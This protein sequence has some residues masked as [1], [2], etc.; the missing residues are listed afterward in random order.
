ML[1]SMYVATVPNRNSP[2]AILIRESYR[3]NGK[4]KTRTLANITNWSPDRIEALRQ[5]L[6]NKTY[7]AGLNDSFDITRSLGHGHVAAVLG[8]IYNLGL[9]KIIDKTSSRFRDLVLAMIVSQVLRPSSKLACARGLRADTR[10]SSLSE[11]LLLG[12]VS[13]NDLYDAMDW[14]YERQSGIEEALAKRH[15]QNGMLVLYDMSSAAFE[16]KT[17]P[18]GA[19]GHPK[20]GV[21][22]RLQIVYGLLTTKDGVPIAIEV[23]PGNTGE[24]TTIAKQVTKL[25]RRFG[26]AKVV[27]VGDRGLLTSA[28][29]R[30][31]VLSEQ[32]D[33]ITALRAPQIR[34]LVQEKALQL[35]LFDEMDICEITDPSYPG[36]RLIACRNPF[37]AKERSKKRLSLLEAT[38]RELDQIVQAVNRERSPIR[39]KANIALRVGKII[40]HYKM[41]KHFQI[42]IE[43]DRLS[44]HLNEEKIAA[45]AAL[46]GIYVL[47]STCD[48][49]TLTSQE[50]V[51]S[52]KSLSNVER[53]FRGFNTDLDIRPIYHRAER[54]VRVHVFLR[55]LSYYVSFHMNQALAPMLF[56][57]DDPDDAEAKRISPV[58]PAQRSS[59]AL[60]KAST[61]RS[62]DNIPVHSFA[63]LMDDL[64]SVVANHITPANS[65]LSSFV[66][67]TKPTPIQTRAFE[68]L[69]VSPTLGYM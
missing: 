57:D 68:L 30:Q 5:V 16:G 67:V 69:G 12:D 28:R 7:K 59:K 8:S 45:E 38:K 62:I 17:C 52:Y 14:L 58:A 51:S 31:D 29:L 36:E 66:M 53:V 46:D 47:R 37:L 60:Y 56:K 33:F 65:D 50:V 32:L 39:G 6:R 27:L 40:N 24:P 61:K 35:S 10:S 13:S 4:V 34:A 15:L 22:G 42:E 11:V 44:Y 48:K 9:D 2:P 43:D 54:R 18:L 26:L 49:E 23:F 64:G 21:K 55:M 1:V 41:A 20:D 19:L 3:E 25:K 63:T